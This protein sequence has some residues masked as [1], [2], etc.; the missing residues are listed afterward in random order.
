[1]RRPPA[2]LL[3]L[4]VLLPCPALAGPIIALAG[5]SGE[6][7]P[8]D[9][10]AAAQMA[11]GLLGGE[12]FSYGGSIASALSL[13]AEIYVPG[14]A[15]SGCE[16]RPVTRSTV[17]EGL[18][19]A[20]DAVD[21]LDY[22]SA[23]VL[24][25][26]VAELLPCLAEAA[27]AGDLYDTWFLA[28]LVAFYESDADAASAAF[29]RAAGI[30]P[31]RPWNEA[32]A[33]D[34][35][36]TFLAALQRVVAEAGP[37][38]EPSPD[39]AGRVLLDGA[40]LAGGER[41]PAGAHLIQ[42]SLAEGGA[43]SFVLVLE[44]AGSRDVVHVLGPAGME[45]AIL[46]GRPEVAGVLAERLRALGWQRVLLVDERGGG[47]RFDGTAA[48]FSR[49]GWPEAADAGGSAA[50]D[51]ATRAPVP[52]ATL[53]GLLMLGAGGALGGVGF[54]MHGA[55]WLR[56]NELLESAGSPSFEEYRGLQQENQAGLAIGL[57]GAAV[58]A[59][60]LAVAVGSTVSAKAAPAG[61]AAVPWVVA[62]PGGLA[63]G[64]GGAW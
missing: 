44:R 37:S 26:G 56:G 10:A 35:K 38:L 47:V 20:R 33:P 17:Q 55:A 22:S 62:G 59:G 1:M 15:L 46:Q 42:V 12:E 39:L 57:G 2:S 40:P 16:G 24:L 63:L 11:E 14:I 49:E 50:H 51:Q 29:A 25:A 60:G 64:L 9:E 7:A 32:Y 61:H 43:A 5:S 45:R 19:R 8:P 53:A 23:R 54:G 30:S 6:G 21:E 27:D 3:L 13:D 18:A 48:V 41:P 52:G 36:G 34:A 58:A 28:G 31:T 4:L